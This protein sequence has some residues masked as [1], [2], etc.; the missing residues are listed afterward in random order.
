MQ[1]EIIILGHGSRIPEANYQ[2]IEV[3][4][5][6]AH[7]LDRTVTPAFMFHGTPDLPSVVIEKILIGAKRIIIMPLF[8]FLGTYVSK[9]IHE[10]IKKI[11]TQ[12]PQIDIV[13]AKELGADDIIANLACSRIK[14]TIG[15]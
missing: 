5:K 8:L 2:L 4:K 3:A 9:E 13:F 15:T 12:F 11:R 14:E 10:R 7:I 6:V 1:T